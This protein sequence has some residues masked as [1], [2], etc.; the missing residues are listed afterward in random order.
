[1]LYDTEY[2]FVLFVV[3]GHRRHLIPDT[4]TETFPECREYY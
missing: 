2:G 1:M 4:I 3:N